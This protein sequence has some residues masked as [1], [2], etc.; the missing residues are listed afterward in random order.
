MIQALG[1][2]LAIA[3]CSWIFK[4]HMLTAA[5]LLLAA[6]TA[7]GAAPMFEQH[8]K[9][10]LT[11][12]QKSAFPTGIFFLMVFI[13]LPIANEKVSLVNL[14]GQL[15]SVEGLLSVAAG[16]LI[17]F[18]GG[19]GPAVLSSRPDV[20]TGVILGTLAAVLFF[21]GLPAGPLIAAGLIGLLS[22]AL[23]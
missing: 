2:L 10:A 11:L 6:L 3:L 15:L 12:L 8:H 18:A 13:M 22:G 19:K 9:A 1:A 21:G 16:L 20:L 14:G 23:T 4:D 17:S 7:A 5:A